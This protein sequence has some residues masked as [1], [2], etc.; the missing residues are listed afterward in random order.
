MNIY[1]VISASSAFSVILG[2]GNQKM[3]RIMQE[4]DGSRIYP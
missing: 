2:A 4:I 1:S 3:G